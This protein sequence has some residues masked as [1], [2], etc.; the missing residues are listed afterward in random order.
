MRKRRGALS[1]TTTDNK[2]AGYGHDQKGAAGGSAVDGG[3][4]AVAHTA[5]VTRPRTKAARPLQDLHHRRPRDRPPRGRDHLPRRAPARHQAAASVLLAEARLPAGRQLPRLHGR[6]RRRARAGGELPAHADARHEGQDRHRPRQDRAQDGGGTAGHRSAGA[7]D[8]AR[9]AVGALEDRDPAQ[10][11]DQPLPA[12]RGAAARPQPSRDGGQPRRLHPVQSLRPRLP[13]S[14][15]QRRD[16]HGRPRPRREDRVRLRRSD[17]QL[18][19]RRLR[20]M[21]AGLS[22]RRA[23]AG[24]AGRRGQRPHGRAFP[25][26]RGRQRVPVLRRRLPAH[27]SHQGRQAALRHRPQRP[28]E[29]EPAVREGPL[30]LRLRQQSAAP[31]QADDPQGRRRRRPPTIWSIRPIRGRISAKRPGKRR[32]TAPPPAW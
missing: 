17:G 30:R 21:R 29:P 15:G 6:D 8:L 28:G 24:D 1:M 2:P 4:P 10:G 7:R 25:G 16:R 27:L 32:W 23:D 9:S 13:R 14:A 26:S 31:D 20:R 5:P 3:K 12:P 18:D 19:L 11:R 22:D